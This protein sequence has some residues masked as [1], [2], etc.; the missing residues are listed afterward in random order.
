MALPTLTAAVWAL[1]LNNGNPPT[2]SRRVDVPDAECRKRRRITPINLVTSLSIEHSQAV[3]G[4]E[5]GAPNATLSPQPRT[6]DFLAK[7]EEEG[8]STVQDVPVEE[9]RSDVSGGSPVA[10]KDDNDEDEGGD[11][12]AEG[13]VIKPSKLGAD[14]GCNEN[15]EWNQ[16]LYITLHLC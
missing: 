7:W 14:R 15:D 3:P 10:L 6:W 12:P 8:S 1:Q 16:L 5:S 9:Y 2:S 4:V 13:P 11:V